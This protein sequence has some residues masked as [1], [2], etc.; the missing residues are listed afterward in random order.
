MKF[1]HALL[2]SWRLVKANVV[3]FSLNPK[4]EKQ[5]LLA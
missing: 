4:R 3:I 5:G 2:A 1:H